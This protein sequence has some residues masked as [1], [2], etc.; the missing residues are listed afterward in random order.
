[1]KIMEF[2]VINKTNNKNIRIPQNNVNKLKKIIEFHMRIQ[3]IQT[4][5]KNSCENQDNHENVKFQQDNF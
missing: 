5:H 4:K 2:H 3:K 1:M